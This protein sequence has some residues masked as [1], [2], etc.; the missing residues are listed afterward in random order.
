MTD[1]KM[2]S[3]RDKNDV[4]AGQILGARERQEDSVS[5]RS[6]DDGRS[7]LILLADGMGGHQGG[8]IAS[9]T[10]IDAFT[11]AFFT[12]FSALKIPYRLFGSLER[13]NKE[14]ATVSK[15]SVEL[16]GMGSTLVAATVSAVGLHWISVGDSLL[17]R[18]RGGQIQ[19]LNEDHSMAPLL[20]EAV[21]KGTLT[22]EQAASHK[23]RSALRSAVSGAPIELVD[24][25]DR[26]EQL[27]KGD[28]VLLASD[29]LLTI[30]DREI[31]R[32]ISEKRSAGAQAI[33]K[34]LLDAVS[35]KNKR[36]QDN[37]TVAAIVI[38]RSTNRSETARPS[39]ILRWLV[40]IL[41]GASAAVVGMAIAS[42]H[43]S[44][45]S[46]VSVFTSIS[47]K[48]KDGERLSLPSDSAD[49]S[50]PQPINLSE[51]MPLS[52]NPSSN[53]EASTPSASDP[54]ALLVK[55]EE[56]SPSGAKSEEKT[57]SA[58]AERSISKTE[59]QRKGRSNGSGD[60]A[61]KSTAESKSEAE[62]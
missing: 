8:E 55:G 29:G 54:R 6:F 22:R 21:E 36:R 19:R 13:A 48:L 47:E 57:V 17:L 26:P 12:D 51:P 45:N 40:A 24:I 62:P 56:M 5:H 58:N 35:K 9:R 34:E 7:L 20:D 59:V 2:S 30:A 42:G 61:M 28:V 27:R 44:A 39:P 1:A 33:V 18:V 23:D 53:S 38:G 32:V 60:L 16:E 14:L 50:A 25:S 11:S 41:V 46:I 4:F 10:S 49:S 15:K 52:N 37:T 31:V 43:L 3:L